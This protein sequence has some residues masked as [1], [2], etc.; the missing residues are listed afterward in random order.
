[1][2]R[3]HLSDCP[4]TDCVRVRRLPQRWYACEHPDREADDDMYSHIGCVMCRIRVATLQQE[5]MASA[6]Q[7]E[8]GLSQGPKYTGD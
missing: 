1:M 7:P 8:T 3:F 2:T 6:S 4:C 5:A